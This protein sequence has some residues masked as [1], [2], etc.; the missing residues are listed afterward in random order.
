MDTMQF[1]ITIIN[2][3]LGIY[4]LPLRGYILPFDLNKKC[5]KESNVDLITHLG[6]S[7]SNGYFLMFKF[8][9]IFMNMQIRSFSYMA[10]R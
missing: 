7:L 8:S 10:I 6:T 4:S 2:S 9:L 1:H 3:L 5:A